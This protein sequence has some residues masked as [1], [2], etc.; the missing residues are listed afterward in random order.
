MI[1]GLYFGAYLIFEKFCEK[2]VNENYISETLFNC[3]NIE[4]SND[5][6]PNIMSRTMFPPPGERVKVHFN[7]ETEYNFG[8]H[9]YM[10]TALNK[11]SY[12]TISD[13]KFQL[14]DSIKSAYYKVQKVIA[15]YGKRAE[16]AANDNLRKRWNADPLPPRS[17]GP[18]EQIHFPGQTD[19]QIP[20]FDP[21][22]CLFLP[23]DHAPLK[24]SVYIIAQMNEKG[25]AFFTFSRKKGN[26]L[27]PSAY[28]GI[29]HLKERRGYLWKPL[30][31]QKRPVSGSGSG[32]RRK[33]RT[34][35]KVCCG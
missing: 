15:S 16:A 1:S 29:K 11:E 2:Y 13:V 6:F 17:P 3:L 34:D 25:K 21:V 8:D 7:K 22:Y 10:E 33:S 20:V 35:S 4:Y 27:F 23:C 5:D 18:R 26:F 14:N 30:I 32:V 24:C 31:L 19:S 12:I 28:V 9:C